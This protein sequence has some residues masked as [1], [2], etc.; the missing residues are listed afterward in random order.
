MNEKDCFLSL[1]SISFFLV[2]RHKDPRQR[3]A[4]LIDDLI[5]RPEGPNHYN[6][7][8][9]GLRKSNQH[10][11]AAMMTNVDKELNLVGECM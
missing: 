7:F 11:L 8:L 10:H 2:Q 3:N 1:S 5:L 9:E 6:R 4:S